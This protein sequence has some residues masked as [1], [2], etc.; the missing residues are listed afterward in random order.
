MMEEL[1]YLRKYFRVIEI[2]RFNIVSNYVTGMVTAQDI[3]EF[4][5]KFFDFREKLYKF[6]TDETNLLEIANMKSKLQHYNTEVLEDE[7]I[8]EVAYSNSN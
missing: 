4:K 6:E 5:E 7:N 1:E 2:L 8:L 3:E